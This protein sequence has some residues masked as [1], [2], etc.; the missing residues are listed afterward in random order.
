MSLGEISETGCRVK[1]APGPL[2]GGEM[3]RKAS[4]KGETGSDVLEGGGYNDHV[5]IIKPLRPSHLL[6]TQNQTEG[7]APHVNLSCN[8][9]FHLTD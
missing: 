3:R 8:I 1:K 5:P 7:R 4:E 6:W 9:H 2:E